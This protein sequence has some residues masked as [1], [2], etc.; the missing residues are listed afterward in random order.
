MIFFLNKNFENLPNNINKDF[1]Q[2]KKDVFE[3]LASSLAPSIHGHEYIKKA[4]L[5]LLLGGKTTFQSSV[6]FIMN[7]P[8]VSYK[9]V[10]ILKHKLDLHYYIICT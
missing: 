4:V 6:L 5:C 9:C 2:K 10:R 3:V 8:K 7:S 1:A